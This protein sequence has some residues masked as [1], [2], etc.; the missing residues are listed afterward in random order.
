M[1]VNDTPRTDWVA[2][3][4]KKAYDLKKMTHKQSIESYLALSK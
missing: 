2:R 1:V 4:C 3:F